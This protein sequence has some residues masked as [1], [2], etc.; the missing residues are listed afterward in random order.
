MALLV[1]FLALELFVLEIVVSSFKLISK[2]LSQGKFTV[3]LTE[4]KKKYNEK[5]I[6]EVKNKKDKEK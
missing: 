4:L 5:K 6:K 3:V 1:Y 2:V